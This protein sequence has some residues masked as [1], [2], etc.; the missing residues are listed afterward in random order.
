MWNTQSQRTLFYLFVITGLITVF[1]F[2]YWKFFF[3]FPLTLF[4]WWVI[5]IVLV[6]ELLELLVVLYITWIKP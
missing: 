6:E 3:V 1:S 2:A 4:F 5:P